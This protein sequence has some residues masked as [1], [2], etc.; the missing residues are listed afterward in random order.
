MFAGLFLTQFGVAAFT[1]LIGMFSAG[2]PMYIQWAFV[3]G[4]VSLA[5]TSITGVGFALLI[6]EMFRPLLITTTC[7]TMVCVI[8]LVSTL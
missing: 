8:A 7:L 4:G 3:Y 5:L 2:E 6:G 1:L